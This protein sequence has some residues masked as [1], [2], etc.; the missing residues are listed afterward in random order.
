MPSTFKTTPLTCPT[1]SALVEWP[2]PI[3]LHSLRNTATL[4]T[5]SMPRSMEGTDDQ[6][7][8]DF[9]PA[10]E[11]CFQSIILVSERL[12][13][14]TTYNEKGMNIKGQRNEEEKDNNLLFLVC[15]CKKMWTEIWTKY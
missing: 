5:R 6:F 1:M 3:C 14:G 10:C 9:D 11:F 7:I 13:L 2:S 8:A 15:L 12:D 4:S